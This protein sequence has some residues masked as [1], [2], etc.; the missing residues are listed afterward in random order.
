MEWIELTATVDREAVEAV[1]AVMHEH[2]RGGVIV[3]ENIIP[4]SEWGG[5]EPN[6]DLPVTVRTYIP[7]GRG[8][9]AK[10]KRIE[11]ALW[12]LSQL[13]TISPLSARH[14]D[15]VDWAEAWKSH[16][17]VQKI[18]ARTIV[19]P[20]WRDY[21][22]VEGDIVVELD[23]GMAFGTGLHPTTRLCLEALETAIKPGDRVLDLGTGSGILAIAAI[24]LGA[25]H[26]TA[27][28]NDP[29]AVVAAIANANVNNV[30]DKI[31]VVEGMISSA[32]DEQYDLVIANI[33]ASIVIAVA[34]D[35]AALVRPCGTYLCSGFLDEREI[36]VAL[37]LAAAGF[38]VTGSEAK[39]DWRLLTS[40][41]D[42]G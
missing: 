15:D 17:T 26:V 36:E 6:G 22:P 3:E 31:S 18:G 28:D 37:R 5:W 35:V 21:E 30:G 11:K 20:T 27:I 42:A 32:G 23:P 24:K 8:A 29:V 16:Y 40:V 14:V 33:S 1:S 25:A 10:Q 12:H 39:T 7:A 34:E 9:A 4:T 38:S 2:G 13:R 19:K 41:R